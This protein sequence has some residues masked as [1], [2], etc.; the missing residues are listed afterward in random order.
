MPGCILSF[1][2]RQCFRL[3]VVAHTYELA[4]GRLKQVFEL[5]I[6]VG[7]MMRTGPAWAI[8]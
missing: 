4:C 2:Y 3:G 1:Q 6:S 5:E 7:Y 8:A